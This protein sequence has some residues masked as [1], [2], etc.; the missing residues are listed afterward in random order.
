[1]KLWSIVYFSVHLHLFISFAFHH[2]NIDRH[3]ATWTLSKSETDASRYFDY[4]SSLYTPGLNL[5][6]I[7]SS[8]DS[9]S[10][11]LSALNFTEYVDYNNTGNTDGIYDDTGYASYAGNLP[12]DSDDDSRPYTIRVSHTDHENKNQLFIFEFKL[13]CH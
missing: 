11:L 6:D 3:F 5:D 9:F 2:A 10:N 13:P 12:E 1:M 7:M 4:P 8:S